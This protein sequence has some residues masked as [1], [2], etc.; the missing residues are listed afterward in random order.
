MRGLYEHLEAN[1]VVPSRSS[2]LVM[3]V[4][5]KT[6]LEYERNLLYFIEHGMWEGDGCDYVIIVQQVSSPIGIVPL[7]G[8]DVLHAMSCESFLCCL[9]RMLCV[10][11]QN[12]SAAEAMYCEA[13]WCR[14]DAHAGGH[15]LSLAF[16]PSHTDNFAAHESSVLG[17]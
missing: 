9:Q 15:P 3:Y 4:Y 11:L 6:D 1:V 17:L 2:T 14:A 8:P 16:A 5:S 7:S 10:R 12:M 13:S